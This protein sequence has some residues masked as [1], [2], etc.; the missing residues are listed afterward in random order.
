MGSI[1]GEDRDRPSRSRRTRPLF[2]VRGCMGTI[3]ASS[4]AATLG[5]VTIR[6]GM[7]PSAEAPE[8]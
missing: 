6:A 5:S 8:S 1:T 7:K 2:V 4:A 3:D